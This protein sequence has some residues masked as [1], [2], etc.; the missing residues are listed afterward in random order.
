MEFNY[1]MPTKVYFGENSI[2]KNKELFTTI[3]K[4][5]LI[6]T[7][8]NSAK[9]NGS[10]DDLVK[11]LSEVGVDYILFDEVEENPSLETIEKGSKVGKENKVD[12]VIGIGGGSPMDASKAMAIFIKNPEVTI[13]NI[14]SQKQLNRPSCSCCSHNF[15]NRLRSYSI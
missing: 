15:W 14:F 12:F 8:R 4:K 10:Y 3:G 6:V 2:L 5:A 9:K 13:D 7:G 11:A 1:S